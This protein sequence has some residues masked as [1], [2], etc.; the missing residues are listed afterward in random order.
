MISYAL[1]PAAPIDAPRT[2]PLHHAAKFLA[3]LTVAEAD[4]RAGVLRHELDQIEA[5]HRA[6]AAARDWAGLH[7][8]SGHERSVR[9]AWA[10]MESARRYGFG[11]RGGAS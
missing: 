7:D 10:A 8:L 3:P 5:R 4:Y 1:P 6:L 2:F 11:P 9:A